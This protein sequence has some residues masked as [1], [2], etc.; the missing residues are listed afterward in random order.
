MTLYRDILGKALRISWQYKFLWILAL[1]AA[2]LGSNGGIELAFAGS[3]SLSGQSMAIGFLRE[4][5]TNGTI[6]HILSNLNEQLRTY[7][8]FA[9]GGLL[10]LAVAI[11]LLIWIVTIAQA[12]LLWAIAKLQGKGGTASLRT[13][14]QQGSKSFV[15]VFLVNLLAKAIIFGLLVLV[16]VPF[17]WLYVRTGYTMYNTLYILIAFLALVPLSV[18]LSFIIKYA[19]IAIVYRGDRWSAAWTRSW[20]LFMSNWLVSLE[21]ALLLY[22]INLGATLLFTFLLVMVGL[23]GSMTGLV[24]IILLLTLLGV[25]L[26]AFQN[27]AWVLVYFQLE[28]KSVRS[29]LLRLT[30]AWRNAPQ[31]KKPSARTARKSA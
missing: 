30:D 25:Y 2:L 27:A 1:L 13:S 16:A 23:P 6:A 11:L 4:F 26:V 9:V 17:G 31:P 10:A 3:D 21:I 5:Y 22:M 29:K 8:F 7:P 20:R 12:G 18:L 14:L 15:P 19:A 24:M 28:Q